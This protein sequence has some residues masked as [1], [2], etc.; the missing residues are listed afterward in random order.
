MPDAGLE[1]VTPIGH[2]TLEVILEGPPGLPG[3]MVMAA[4]RPALREHR[5]DAVR[6]DPEIDVAELFGAQARAVEMGNWASR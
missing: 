6:L 4:P 5:R 1:K 3:V 2:N